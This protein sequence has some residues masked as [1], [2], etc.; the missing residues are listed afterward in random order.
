ML[1]FYFF[2]SVLSCDDEMKFSIF[3]FTPLFFPSDKETTVKR[4]LVVLLYDALRD[5][6]S[7]NNRH[8]ENDGAPC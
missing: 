2:L 4:F 7:K 8:Y 1:F 3:V 5:V 6:G